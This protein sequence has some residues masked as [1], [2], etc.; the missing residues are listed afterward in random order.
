MTT[1]PTP[2]ESEHPRRKFLLA[3][4]MG[5]GA[6]GVVATAIPFVR[7]MDPS[8]RALAAGAPA[9][10]DLAKLA[11]GAIMTVGWRGK[12]VWVLHR[13]P[14][15]LATLGNHNALLLDP[16]STTDQ[17]PDYARNPTRSRE[18]AYFVAIGICTHLGCVPVFRPEPNAPG[19][20]ADW[21]GGFYCPCHGSKYD[22]AGRVF[23]NMPA[24]LNLEI[25]PY[26]LL[27]DNKLLIGEERAVVHTA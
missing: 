26:T 16:N 2:D 22:L 19:L 8:A 18:P 6:I 23:R 4:T 24:P 7:S 3:T 11:P 10:V 13:T 9:E 5:V 15:M 21:P 12:P 14:A 27:P 1:S 17:Q 25:P 20:G